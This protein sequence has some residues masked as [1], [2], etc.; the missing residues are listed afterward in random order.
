MSKPE[1][2]DVLVIGAGAA[3]TVAAIQSAR[4]GA[5][6]LLVEKN[7]IAG[8]T[9]TVA[10]IAFPG[11]FYAWGEPVIA[12]I[13]WELVT[14]AVREAGTEL[15]DF[16]AQGGR[17]Q[18]PRYQ[19][20]LSAPLYAAI[21]DEAL[22]TA[23]V[24]LLFHTMPAALHRTGEGF[25][26][27]LCTKT[28]LRRVT[29]KIVIDTSGDATGA[30]LAGCALIEPGEVQPATLSC[31]L[32]GYD[33]EKLTLEPIARAAAEAVARG[34]LRY[35]DLG[36]NHDG[37]SPNFLRFHGRNANHV[38]CASDAATSEGRTRLELEGRR[39]L[40][41]A[42]RFLRRQPGLEQLQLLWAA[43]ET[44]VRESVVIR[45]RHTITGVEYAAGIR[46][47]DGVCHAFYPID[48]HDHRRGIVPENLKPGVKPSVPLRALLPEQEDRLLVAGRILASDRA[49]NSALRVQATAMATGQV[50]GAAAALAA[51]AG[52]VPAALAVSALRRELAAHGAILPPLAEEGAATDPAEHCDR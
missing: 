14:A 28:G 50:A 42:W 8:G 24:E 31:R 1:A 45:G 48:L 33:F 20:P 11:L 49:A 51:A 7:G 38:A 37:F 43:M 25:E 17:A 16:T 13:G 4:S 10:G 34:E 27:E 6:T 46:Y 29:A 5:R 52:T 3:G 15:P 40:L 36:W 19:I 12:G 47:P 44:G 2:Y 22:L 21:C 39:A 41:R 32:E 35:T 23:G 30:R 18:H 9:I 26:A